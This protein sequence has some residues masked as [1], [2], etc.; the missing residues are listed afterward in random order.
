MPYLVDGNNLLGALGRAPD[1]REPDGAALVSEI[2]GRLRQV[3]AR[4][5]LVFDGASAI[6]RDR[7]ALGHLEVRHAGSRSA[8]DV[9]VEI[10]QRSASPRD[11]TVV[12]EDRGLASRARQA[13]ARTMRVADFWRRFGAGRALHS[14]EARR[15][16]PSLEEWLAYFGDDRNRGV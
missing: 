8:D 1:R 7:T 10:V 6:G 4:L 9:I 12:T 13:G 3:K 11:W 16:G 14:D 5:T 15:G 2:C